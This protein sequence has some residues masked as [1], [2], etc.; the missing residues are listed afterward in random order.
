MLW[1]YICAKD[2]WVRARHEWRI[3]SWVLRYHASYIFHCPTPASYRSFSHSSSITIENV[4]HNI[5]LTT[6]W[7]IQAFRVFF[8][9][10]T[11]RTMMQ[12]CRAHVTSWDCSV[13]Q[14]CRETIFIYLSKNSTHGLHLRL[15]WPARHRARSRHSLRQLCRAAE[16]RVS[17]RQHDSLTRFI[18]K[19]FYFL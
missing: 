13:A 1:Y 4:L 9:H 5:L 8:N 16:L 19:I 7:R 3:W 12:L 14:S 11:I 2:A 18:V 15:H 10:R 6:F 17:A